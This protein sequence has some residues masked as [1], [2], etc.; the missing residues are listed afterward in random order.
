[1]LSRT[2]GSMVSVTPGNFTKAMSHKLPHGPSDSISNITWSHEPNPNFIAASSWDNTVRIWEIQTGLNNTP[3]PQAKVMFQHDAPILSCYFYP[4]NSKFFAGGCDKMVKVYDL[5]SGSSQGMQIAQHDQPVSSIAWS[6]HLSVLITVSWDGM[7]KMW[8]GKSANP[9]LQKNIQSKIYAMDLNG[10]ILC[11]GDNQRQLFVWDLSK[12]LDHQPLK[13]ISTLKMQTR[14]LSLFP[15][16]SSAPGVAVGSIEGRCAIM[17]FDENMSK[18]QNFCF[19]CHR[20]EER[21]VSSIY[22]VNCISFHSKRPTFATGGSDGKIILWDKDTRHRVKQFDP[23]GTPVTACK[24]NRSNNLMAYAE[25]Y[26]WHK[27][28]DPQELQNPNFNVYVH[29]FKDDDIIPKAKPVL[30]R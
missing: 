30:H 20:V 23:L 24:F 6:T 15:T 9:V 3:S 18:S 25:G 17:H 27:G 14:S 12:S 7:L 2:S 22:S 4:D 8:D 28:V 10:S 19:K 26:D 5:N 13:L 21:G 1:M 16:N 29:S 11:I